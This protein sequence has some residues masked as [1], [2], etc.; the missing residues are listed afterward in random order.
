MS[1]NNSQ[2]SDLMSSFLN[3]IGLVMKPPDKTL[4]ISKQ[5]TKDVAGTFKLTRAER[6]NIKTKIITQVL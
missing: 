1:F 5:M 4:L 3:R 2:S 6:C